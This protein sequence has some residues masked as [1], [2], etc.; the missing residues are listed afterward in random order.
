MTF[1]NKT[2]ARNALATSSLSSLLEHILVKKFF[3][4]L[5]INQDKEMG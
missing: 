3:P 2:F 1:I 5:V 4:Y